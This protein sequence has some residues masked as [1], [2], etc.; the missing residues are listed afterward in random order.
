MQDGALQ[1]NSPDKPIVWESPIIWPHARNPDVVLSVG[2]GYS[3]PVENGPLRGIL[4]DGCIPRLIRA[5]KSSPSLNGQNGWEAHMNQVDIIA[6]DDYF[7]LNAPLPIPEPQLDQA[8][9]MPMLRRIVRDFIA[10]TD[11]YSPLVRAMWASA[12]YFE[13]ERKPAY[14]HGMYY[15]CGSILSRAVQNVDMIGHVLKHYPRARFQ[16]KQNMALGWLK[17]ADFCR[18]CNVY[19]KSIAFDLRHLDDVVDIQL[20]F[21]AEFS[22]R[23][24]GSGHT[25]RWYS[26]RQ[27]LDAHFGRKDHKETWAPSTC[28]CAGPDIP[29]KRKAQ[30]PSMCGSGSNKRRRTGSR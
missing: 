10:S 1:H 24:S 3:A 4:T 17:M 13:L 29:A 25:V 23:I 28:L 21:S 12:F 30:E 8:E 22:R 19:R 27:Q 18:T 11:L 20:A 7:R 6:R 14:L 16:F 15:C 9:K 2:A 26:E 5:L